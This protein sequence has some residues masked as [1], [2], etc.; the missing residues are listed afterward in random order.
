MRFTIKEYSHGK[1][2][3]SVAFKQEVVDALLQKNLNAALVSGNLITFF[4]EKKA[5]SLSED[6]CETLSF[7]ENYDVLFV[8]ESGGGWTLFSNEKD[9][10]PLILTQRCNS[11]CVMCPTPEGV[12]K[13]ENALAIEDTIDSIRY[14]PDDA[15]HLTITGGEPF[16][17]GEKIF[18]L[19]GEIKNRLPYTDCLLLTNG[20]ALGYLPY[21]E[22]FVCSAPQ[23]IVVGIP[24]HGFD[25]AT[26]DAITQSPGGFEQ[27]VVGIKNLIYRGI[28]VELRMVVSKLNYRNI[29]RIAQL[30]IREFPNVGSVKI[31]GL[32]MLGNAAKN[33]NDV[34]IPYRTAFECSKVGIEELIRHGINVGLYNFPLCAVDKSFHLICQKSISGYKIRYSDKCELC[35][36]KPGCGGIFAGSIRLAKNDVVP[37][38]ETK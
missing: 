10:N 5:F 27:T 16:L 37:F 35:A 13:R 33:V 34:W 4:P 2:I 11:N 26:H 25:G 23:H 30:I 9:D 28:N 19:L 22:R 31:M 18:D 14:I 36:N 24:L 17:V 6:S 32:E 1:K 20:R 15:R 38:L 12:R 21:A 3:F 29:E 8:N 7:C